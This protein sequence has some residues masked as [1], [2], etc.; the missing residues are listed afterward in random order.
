MPAHLTH[1]T[2]LRCVLVPVAP[3]D[4]RPKRTNYLH[5]KL[6]IPADDTITP[7][8]ATICHA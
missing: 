6:S 4:A 1:N 8:L 5:D 7:R 3:V 2:E